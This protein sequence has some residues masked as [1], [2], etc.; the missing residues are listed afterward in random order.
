MGIKHTTEIIRYK[1]NSKEWVAVAQSEGKVIGIMTYRITGFWKEIKIRDFFYSNSLGKFLLLQYIAIHA[2]QVKEIQITIKPDEYP[3][4]WIN[5][6][7]W[8]ENGKI[9][10][11][12]WVPSCMGRIIQVEKMSGLKVGDGNISVKIS[13]DSCEWNNKC[14]NLVSNSGVLEVTE[15]DQFECELTI[16]GLSAI[17]YGCY[18][19]DDFEFKGWGQ[20]TADAKLKIE[21]LFPKKSPFLYADF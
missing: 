10:S 9:I 13:D 15:A 17:I 12:P 5:D 20:M 2:D 4:T 11:R 18:N 6:T 19:L 14:F 3:E 8:G 16:Q 21:K 7:F 1:D